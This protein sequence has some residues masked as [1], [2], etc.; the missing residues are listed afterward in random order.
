MLIL[1]ATL[2]STQHSASNAG[3]QQADSNQHVFNFLLP[4]PCESIQ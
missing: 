3:C 1:S 2:A 4:I